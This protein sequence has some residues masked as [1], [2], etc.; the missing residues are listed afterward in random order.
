MD[1][2]LRSTL[3]LVAP[4]KMIKHRDKKPAPWYSD[5]TRELKQ[6]SRKLER[7]WRS[8]KLEQPHEPPR[9]PNPSAI[10]KGRVTRNMNGSLPSPLG[11][12]M[13]P[14][15]LRLCAK[16]QFRIPTLF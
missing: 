5:H 8:T 1:K 3:D 7:K 4:L 13:G 9:S 15:C 6:A 14:D 11:G 10:F 12:G 2:S 16:W